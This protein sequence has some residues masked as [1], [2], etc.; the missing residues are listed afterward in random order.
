MTDVGHA[1]HNDGI[2]RDMMP[3]RLQFW[4]QTW[5]QVYDA[6]GA[7]LL[8]KR[9]DT[10]L[11]RHVLD[12]CRLI[13]RLFWKNTLLSSVRR[14]GWSFAV[15]TEGHVGGA[16]LGMRPSEYPVGN[17]T[18]HPVHKTVTLT[19]QSS[20]CQTSV[21]DAIDVAVVLPTLPAPL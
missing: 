10:M 1:R 18:V 19:I 20:V 15:Q 21:H 16:A 5:K 14:R 12:L 3:V 7:G 9:S 6:C 11:D 8:P 13:D 2:F 4:V 17:I